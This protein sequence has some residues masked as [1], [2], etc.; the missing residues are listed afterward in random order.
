MSKS[1]TKI[2]PDLTIPG[3]TVKVEDSHSCQVKS[4]DGRYEFSAQFGAKLI[5]IYGPIFPT[6]LQDAGVRSWSDNTFDYSTDADDVITHVANSLRLMDKLSS[7]GVSAKIDGYWLVLSHPSK[8][9]YSLRMHLTDARKFAFCADP[10]VY[11]VVE[12]CGPAYDEKINAKWQADINNHRLIV[13]NKGL[14]E[15]AQ[16]IK[17]RVL[18]LGEKKDPRIAHWV[19]EEI[20]SA[21]APQGFT[22]IPKPEKGIVEFSHPTGVS[23]SLLFALFTKGIEWDIRPKYP[24]LHFP[25]DIER[26]KVVL[27][28]LDRPN[29]RE[30]YTKGF[31]AEEPEEVIHE[32]RRLLALRLVYQ[33]VS[34]AWKS[35]LLVPK[36]RESRMLLVNT[37]LDGKEAIVLE[38]TREKDKLVLSGMGEKLSYPILDTPTVVDTEAITRAIVERAEKYVQEFSQKTGYIFSQVVE[39]PE[40]DF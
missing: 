29:Y 30:P 40:L 11:T 7:E 5:K 2:S 18:S 35:D 8:P 20:E 10:S 33:E 17:A 12:Y 16:E 6:P 26:E 9:D 23:G 15:L 1:P 36:L 39:I 34:H 13:T 21:L 38:L 37:E 24:D 27:F 14:D 32:F 25:T 31:L 3:F 28:T 22:F 4:K 19:K